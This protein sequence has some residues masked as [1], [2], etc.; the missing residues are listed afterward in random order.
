MNIFLLMLVI[1][2]F[3]PDPGF[4]L[5]TLRAQLHARNDL[6]SAILTNNRQL[7]QTALNEKADPEQTIILSQDESTAF[8]SL[9]ARTYYYYSNGSDFRPFSP[10]CLPALRN[11]DLSVTDRGGRKTIRCQ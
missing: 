9:S 7:A 3:A 4:S 5:A 1:G 2:Q 6:V 8:Q 10:I 11:R